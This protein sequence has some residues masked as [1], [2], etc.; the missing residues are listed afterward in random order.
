MQHEAD[1]PDDATNIAVGLAEVFKPGVL[2]R[3]LRRCDELMPAGPFVFGAVELV[4]IV[5]FRQGHEVQRRK[6]VAALKRETCRFKIQ[7]TEGLLADT[8]PL[9]VVRLAVRLENFRV[10]EF[11]G[12]GRPVDAVEP[13]AIGFQLIR[14]IAAEQHV[15]YRSEAAMLREESLRVLAAVAQHPQT[16]RMVLRSLGQI[17]VGQIADWPDDRRA[18]IGYRA[19]GLHAYEMVRDG[20]ILSLLT[21]EEYNKT[22]EDQTL[23]HL[24]IALQ[25]KGV[26]D[27]DELFYL[28]TMQRLIDACKQPYYLR[29]PLF[30]ELR[31][32]QDDAKRSSE[33]RYIS[34][35]ILLPGTEQVHEDQARD[36]ARCEAWT[37]AIAKAVGAP[38]PEFKLNP[39]SGKPYQIAIESKDGQPLRIVVTG[40]GDGTAADDEPIIVPIHKF[41]KAAE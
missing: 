5:Q 31:Q 19:V 7:F 8:S 37:L 24:P 14:L 25:G 9:D 12:E 34:E 2:K 3:A 23:I 16:S 21:D 10:A 36:R 20:Q 1:W 18:W 15:A 22:I 33:F 32:E 38:L 6:V 26:L 17:L 28:Q 11:L 35:R 27:H 29:K 40:V 13:L 39:L 41:G 4:P 30:D